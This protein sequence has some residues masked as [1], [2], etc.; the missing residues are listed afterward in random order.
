MM[1]A[2]NLAIVFGVNLARD[3]NS[4]SLAE[5]SFGDRPL[6]E[7]MITNYNSIFSSFRRAGIRGK[8]ERMNR[9]KSLIGI[10]RVSLTKSA[11]TTPIPPSTPPVG[12]LERETKLTSTSNLP[13]VAADIKLR[14]NRTAK[15][16]K[17][18][19]H[20]MKDVQVV[21]PIRERPR[22]T[23]LLS[24]EQLLCYCCSQEISKT[25]YA[26]FIDAEHRCHQNCFVCSGC[27]VP[28]EFGN[29]EIDKKKLFCVPCSLGL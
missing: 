11:E 3:C 12:K 22:R 18:K 4:D 7:E 26:I 28:L 10:G 17:T 21:K 9:S 25:S 5:I 15:K 16:S 14:K 24:P 8:R 27:D 23:L 1:N 19:V 20:P 6:F 13:T 29:F 2:S